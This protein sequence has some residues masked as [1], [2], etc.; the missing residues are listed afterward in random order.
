M[1]IESSQEGSCETVAEETGKGPAW[2]K[3]GRREMGWADCREEAEPSACAAGVRGT[4]PAV[5]ITDSN[6][7]PV[8]GAAQRGPHTQCLRDMH[9]SVS[10]T[11]RH[12]S[13]T[14][15]EG[16]RG[17]LDCR[18]PACVKVQSSSRHPLAVTHVSVNLMELETRL[19]STCRSLTGSPSTTG[20]TCKQASKLCVDEGCSSRHIARS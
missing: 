2:S 13:S 18:V 20:G 7:E 5:C 16:E 3:Q 1:P 8:C 12:S 15:G 6:T 11:I 4:R 9:K 14:A 17:M 10:E 19:R